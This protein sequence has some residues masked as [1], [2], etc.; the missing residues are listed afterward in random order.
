MSNISR[1]SKSHILAMNHT[2]L[3]LTLMKKATMMPMTNQTKSITNHHQKT[4]LAT[5]LPMMLRNNVIKRMSPTQL[6]LMCFHQMLWR[7]H[8][9]TI[10]TV[11]VTIRRA[12]RMPKESWIRRLAKMLAKLRLKC[13]KENFSQFIVL[14]FIIFFLSSN[15]KY[16]FLCLNYSIM[17]IV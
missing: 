2:N 3:M 10:R 16:F 9:K 17:F 12:R 6:P 13:K 4:I 1:S 8:N 5:A 14:R 15:L 11:R 7:N